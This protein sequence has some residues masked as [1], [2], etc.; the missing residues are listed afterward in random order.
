MRG[1]IEQVSNMLRRKAIM[2]LVTMAAIFGG[3]IATPAA[4]QA[5]PA[6]TCRYSM[7]PGYA[8][9]GCDH[10]VQITTRMVLTCEVIGSDFTYRRYSVW[11]SGKWI[12]WGEWLFCHGGTARATGVHFEAK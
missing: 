10:H 4:A 8:S 5:G 6:A 11:H 12:C 3:I 7:G 9:G 2:A 1:R